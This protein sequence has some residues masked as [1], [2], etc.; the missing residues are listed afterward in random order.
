MVWIYGGS[1]L[2]G[3]NNASVYGPDFFMEQDVVLVTF[4]YRLGALGTIIL[5]Y[6]RLTSFSIQINP[7]F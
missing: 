1:F 6:N 5:S 2:D 4:N 7:F 3:S